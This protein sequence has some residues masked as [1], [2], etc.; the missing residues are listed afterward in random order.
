MTTAQSPSSVAAFDADAFTRFEQAGWEDKAGGWH[1]Y[2]E[3]VSTQSV[4][5]LLRAVGL[6]A[7]SGGAG[8]R[9]LDVATGPGYAAAAA[10]RRG[11]EAIGVD[12]ATAQV[13]LA[14][15]NFPEARFEVADAEALPFEDASFDAMVINPS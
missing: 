10:A 4:D 1:H 14:S 13:R 3:R 12:F 2:F 5:A 15:A 11:A 9:L 6:P 8:R 7:N